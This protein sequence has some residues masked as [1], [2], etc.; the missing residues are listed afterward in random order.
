MAAPGFAAPGGPGSLR[1]YPDAYTACQGA[2]V[3]VVLMEWDKFRW[4]DFVRAR[5]ALAAPV[6]VDTRNLLDPA[7]VRWPGFSYVGRGRR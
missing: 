7:H 3:A 1:T 4:L 5:E 2:A 6:V